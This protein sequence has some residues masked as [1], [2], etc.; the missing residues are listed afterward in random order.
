[1]GLPVYDEIL[2]RRS[3]WKGELVDDLGGG[4]PPAEPARHEA[5]PAPAAMSLSDLC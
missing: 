2:T 3:V 4:P 1:M 5:P